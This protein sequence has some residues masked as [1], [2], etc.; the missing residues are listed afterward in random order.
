M[1][2]PAAAAHDGPYARAV[3]HLSKSVRALLP[4]GFFTFIPN[5]RC[6]IKENDDV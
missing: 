2:G 1:F 4:Y 5:V 3:R 6:T